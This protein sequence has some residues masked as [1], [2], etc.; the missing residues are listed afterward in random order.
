M[1]R[2]NY[3]YE[4]A[5]KCKDLKEWQETSPNFVYGNLHPY[6]ITKIDELR[7]RKFS[8]KICYHVNKDCCIICKNLGKLWWHWNAPNI[9][10]C[11]IMIQKSYRRYLYSKSLFIRSKKIFIRLLILR[12][13]EDKNKIILSNDIHREILLFLKL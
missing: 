13:L 12:R 8:S 5:I 3:S 4:I 2:H 9:A 6:P 1:D 10:R 7:L 11:I